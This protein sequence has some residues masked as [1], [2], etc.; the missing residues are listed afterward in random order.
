MRRIFTAAALTVAALTGLSLAGPSVVSAGASSQAAAARIA[1]HYSKG[2]AGYSVTGGWRFRYI[3]TTLTVPAST[4][5]ATSAQIGLMS[6]EDA[7]VLTVKS[8]GGPDSISYHISYWDTAKT[9]A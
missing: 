9:L 2:N 4:T 7:V 5:R 6:P 8:G 3:K 1:N